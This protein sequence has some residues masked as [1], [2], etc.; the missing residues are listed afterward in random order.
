MLAGARR[1]VGRGPRGPRTLRGGARVLPPGPSSG[2]LW[3]LSRAQ[4][5]PCFSVSVTPLILRLESADGGVEPLRRRSPLLPLP[6]SP[7][8]FLLRASADV[9]FSW[10][11]LAGAEPRRFHTFLLANSTVLLPAAEGEPGAGDPQT[12]LVLPPVLLLIGS[13]RLKGAG[14]GGGG[15]LS[16]VS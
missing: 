3:L 16:P 5:Q 12:A 15:M 1:G 7:R 14:E 2:W 13:G 10:R 9:Y 6:S 11:V 8:L 4:E